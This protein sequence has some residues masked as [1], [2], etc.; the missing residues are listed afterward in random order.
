MVAECECAMCMNVLIKS[1]FAYPCGHAFCRECSQDVDNAA[2]SNNTTA[3]AARNTRGT[4]KRRGTCPTCRSPVEGWMQ[5]RAFDTL[6]WS[7]ALQGCFERSDAE[8]YLR[9]REE[10]D[11]AAPSE[12]ERGSI[13]NI[14]EGESG[15]SN[16]SNM[17]MMGA[18][19][20]NGLVSHNPSMQPL[21][22]QN[23]AQMIA[24]ANN[25]NNVSSSMMY[26]L[27]TRRRQNRAKS[28]SG[29]NEVICID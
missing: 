24:N 7:V 8:E 1:T 4:L 13:L 16:N 15:Q 19:M 26:Q 20:M 21:P 2:A 27:P 14:E 25:G 11:E 3:N 5:A 22:P 28:S 9:R 29:D 6:V 23:P 17:Y 18:M 10:A 12:E